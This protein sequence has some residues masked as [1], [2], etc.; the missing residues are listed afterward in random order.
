M[1]ARRSGLPARFV[2][3]YSSGS[4]DAPNAEY[5]VRELNA[6]SWAEVYFPGIGWIEFEPTGSQPE[7]ER[8]EKSVELPAVSQ[9]PTQTEKLLF[10]LTSTDVL[11]WISPFVVALLL[12]VLYF[13]VLERFWVLN[14]APASAIAI[15]YHRYYRMGRPL[16]GARTGAETASEFTSRLIYNIDEISVR[17]RRTQTSK[18]IKENVQQLTKL[19]L[20]SV[21]SN[22]SIEKGDARKAFD[23]WKRLRR[24]LWLTRLKG[25]FLR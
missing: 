24:Q 11:Y 8:L 4:Y 25:Y 20:L 3:G 6:H 9:P 14:R 1:L 17:S 10:K 21:F 18:S 12:V 5:V 16:A 2:S 15:L 13:A 7:I 19:Y 22:H 23:L